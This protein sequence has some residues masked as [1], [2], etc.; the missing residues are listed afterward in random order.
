VGYVSSDFGN[1]PLSHLMGAVF[2]MHDHRCF[3]RW[4]GGG[5]QWREVQWGCGRVRTRL[6]RLEPNLAA[7][8]CPCWRP[9]WWPGN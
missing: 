1:H 4:G 6:L 5:V 9:G 3:G 8:V 7:T 2:G